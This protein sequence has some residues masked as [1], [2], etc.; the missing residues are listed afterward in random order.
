MKQ[1]RGN[2]FVLHAVQIARI[3]CIF[4]FHQVV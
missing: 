2:S 1:E 3:F 4:N